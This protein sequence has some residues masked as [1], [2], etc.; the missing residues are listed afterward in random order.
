MSNEIDNDTV[1]Q[2]WEDSWIEENTKKL[3]KNAQNS[4]LEEPYF[5]SG[6]SSYSAKP[7]FFGAG[8]VYFFAR[9]L[10]SIVSAFQSLIWHT[11]NHQSKASPLS[12]TDTSVMCAA[13]HKI[14][15]PINKAVYQAPTAVECTEKFEDE[16]IVYRP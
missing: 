12:N 16:G 6:L 4:A 3:K 7:V 8:I 1:G 13:S 5:K 10:S 15:K 11:T 2:N 14:S 9:L